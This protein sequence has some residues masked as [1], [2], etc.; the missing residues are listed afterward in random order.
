MSVWE[1]NGESA[2][3]RYD[4]GFDGSLEV[5]QIRELSSDGGMGILAQA[6]TGDIGVYMFNDGEAPT[7]SHIGNLPTD[8]ELL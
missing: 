3:Q 2:E 1:M 5:L 8:W 7:F 6:P 4:F